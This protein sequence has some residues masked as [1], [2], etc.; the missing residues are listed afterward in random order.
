MR[1]KTPLK[2]IHVGPTCI[3]GSPFGTTTVNGCL[4]DVAAHAHTTGCKPIGYIC[5][6]S[7]K[8]L[9]RFLVHELAHLAVDSGH[10]DSWRKSVRRMG[11]H[12]PAAYKKRPRQ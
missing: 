4:Y 7:K 9:T 2:G 12:V 3:D 10:S 1:F 5:A 8:E 6:R 11:G